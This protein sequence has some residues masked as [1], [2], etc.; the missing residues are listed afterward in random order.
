MIKLLVPFYENKKQS[1]T[2]Q[3]VYEMRNARYLYV[4]HNIGVK[5]VEVCAAKLQCARASSIINRVFSLNVE[6]IKE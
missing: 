6:S 5:N 1:D 2:V 4:G 3:S